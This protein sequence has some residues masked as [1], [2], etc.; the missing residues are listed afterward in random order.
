M[1]RRI[2]PYLFILPAGAVIFFFL[3]YPLVYSFFISLHEW[4]LSP[5]M[6]FVGLGNYA[7]ILSSPEFWDSMLYT[8]YYIVGVLPFSLVLGFLFASLLNDA[9]LK[10]IGFFRT[11]YFLPVVTSPIAA[12]MGFSFLF[13]TELG[14]VN[15]LIR[16]M[17]G[18]YVNW[19]TNPE[20][21]VQ[22][23]F[24]WTGIQLPKILQGP[25]VALF[26]IILMGIWQ[27]VGYAMVVYLAGMQGIPETYY[28]AASLSGATRFQCLRKITIP[29]LSPTTFFLLIMFSINS[30]QVFGPVMVMTP[31]GGP[32]N[33]TSV[34]VF[35]LYREAFAYYRFGYA[36]AMA[37]VLFIFV[38]SMTAFQVKTLERRVH[39]E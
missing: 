2:T 18:E 29:L 17:G 27:N 4:D 13:S 37:F 20:G 16:S 25:S 34:V 12:G 32:L 11:V 21:I 9:T 30:F 3:L 7:K 8:A 38:I 33:T 19:L 1:R 5:G 15:H 26:V 28:E 14:Y 35:R 6:T 39:Y 36:A 23:L 24:N 10:G 22:I 31:E